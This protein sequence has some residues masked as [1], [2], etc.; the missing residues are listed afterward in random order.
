MSKVKVGLIGSGFIADIHAAALAMV[1]EADI[2]AV[3]SPSPGKAKQFAKERNIPKSF[4]NYR[5]LL[6]VEEIDMIS[7]CLPNDLHAQVTID[8]AGAGKHV[9]CEKPLCCTL[10][11]ADQMI[12]ACRE[13][14]QEIGRRPCF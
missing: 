2:V 8:A 10:T 11:E 4:Q 12:A 6:A 3:A 1:P 9:L 5:D 14:G 13:A 7:L